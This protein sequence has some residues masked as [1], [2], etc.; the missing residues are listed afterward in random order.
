[1]TLSDYLVA[2]Q[3]GLTLLG[4]YALTDA[5]KRVLGARA[6]LPWVS[7]LLP[8]VPVA[9]GLLAALV[10]GWL[11]GDGLGERLMGGGLV[12]AVAPLVHGVVKR[13]AGIEP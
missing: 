13:R 7:R 12:G 1:M 9:V 5:A 4:A 8:L 6:E 2:Y 10:P 3:V 11:P